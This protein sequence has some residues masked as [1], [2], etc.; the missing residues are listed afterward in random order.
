MTKTLASLL[1]QTKDDLQPIY[2]A[3]GNTYHVVSYG[4]S[5]LIYKNN[6]SSSETTD[7]G[8]IFIGGI[9]GGTIYAINTEE[10]DQP[11]IKN[12]FEERQTLGKEFVEEFAEELLKKGLPKATAEIRANALYY[13]KNNKF[14]N[15]PLPTLPGYGVKTKELIKYLSGGITK[16]ELKNQ[17]F[18][19]LHQSAFYR[20][21]EQFLLT[22]R[23]IDHLQDDLLTEEQ[24]Q[25]VTLLDSLSVTTLEV[26]FPGKT[27]H[28]SSV[29]TT[30]DI[31]NI[32]R[33]VIM[34]PDF[35]PI[36][37][38]RNGKILYQQESEQSHLIR[39]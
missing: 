13:A 6:L 5:H 18:E 15:K 4:G 29:F 26:E 35:S 21:I 38:F 2:L 30:M 33:E 24:E 17:F 37:L 11:T 39:L 8:M 3:D 25:L 28:E 32:R 27:P 7:L 22:K 31:D 19:A 20:Q 34:N 10:L 9:F 16:E 23:E 14:F 12:L 36:R 1:E